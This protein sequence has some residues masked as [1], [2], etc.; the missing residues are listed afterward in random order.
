[1]FTTNGEIIILLFDESFIEQ[2][3]Y[4]DDLN[5]IFL[6]LGLLS[7]CCKLHL[8][9]PNQNRNWSTN[10]SSSTYTGTSPNLSLGQKC[11]KG[12]IRRDSVRKSGATVKEV[13]VSHINLK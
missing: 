8:R 9:K 10:I 2:L 5:S 11:S 1:M 12:G 6:H 3:H 4:S 13:S 7:T